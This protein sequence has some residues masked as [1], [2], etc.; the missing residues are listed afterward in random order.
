M[1]KKNPVLKNAQK[2]G[3][4]QQ[5]TVMGGAIS[6]GNRR[7]CEWDDVTGKCYIWTCDRC[8]CP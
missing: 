3:R 5:K 6:P 4:E 7:C 1:N 2:L 8:Q